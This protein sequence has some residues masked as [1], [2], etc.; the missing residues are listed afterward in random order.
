M[1]I[2]AFLV[3][4]STEFTSIVTFF[5]LIIFLLLR[6]NL[7]KSYI[8]PFISLI[9]AIC[10][11]YFNEGFNAVLAGHSPIF[12]NMETF[13]SELIFVKPFLIS[14]VDVIIHVYGIYLIPLLILTV[15][16][17]V[18][19][20]K[21][22][23]SNGNLLFPLVLILGCMF[24][25]VFLVSNP[26]LSP[27]L[28]YWVYH[29]DLVIQVKILLMIIALY[30]LNYIKIKNIY[31][32]VAIISIILIIVT[33]ISL[34]NAEFIKSCFNN[35]LMNSVLKDPNI[36]RDRYVYEKINLFYLKKYN[37]MVFIPQKFVGYL[38]PLEENYYN[39]VYNIKRENIK[40][41]VNYDNLEKLYDNYIKDGGENISEEE[42]EK[43]DF[44][45]LL[46][47]N[48]EKKGN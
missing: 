10:L 14:C 39:M 28:T 35:G 13:K 29:F 26:D 23:V 32:N 36:W 43:A 41:I 7:I 16:I 11:Y 30:E 34:K 15:Y 19:N 4:I 40:E 46:D 38:P 33:S 27:D 25:Q 44:Q 31:K 47:E 21:E 45:K 5:A 17:I 2:Y 37:K 48:K 6:K 22:N 42:R 8:L 3:G 1:S 12:F 20:R 18:Q 24:F 9:I